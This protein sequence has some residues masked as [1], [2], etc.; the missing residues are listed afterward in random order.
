QRARRAVGCGG[1]RWRRL[2]GRLRERPRA[3]AR[4][5]ARSGGRRRTLNDAFARFAAPKTGTWFCEPGSCAS[6]SLVLR[7]R[8]PGSTN[9]VPAF[10]ASALPD[11]ERAVARVAGEWG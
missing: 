2:D 3:G 5:R 6:G 7:F 1:R 9:Q 8:E 4:A 10:L 11:G